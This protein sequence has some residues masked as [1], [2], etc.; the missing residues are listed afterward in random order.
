MEEESN[1]ELAFLDTSLKRNDGKISALVHRKLTFTIQ[2]L[3]YNSQH[4]TSCKETVVSFL[5]N[6]AC[7]VIS[8]ED[9]L[10]KA[11]CINY[12]VNRKIEELQQIKTISF[13]KFDCSNCETVYFGESKRSL[14]WCSNEHKRSVRNWDC[15][16]TETAKHC[17]EVD[18]DFRWDQ[19]RLL[20]GETG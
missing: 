11:L 9:D 7:S 19:K 6:R 3:H 16:K 5:V 8:N 4:Q 12:F 20:I 15:E 13:I 17:W 1:G 2:Y 14:K 10:T 18:Q